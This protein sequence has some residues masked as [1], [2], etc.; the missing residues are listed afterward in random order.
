MGIPP[1]ALLL[2]RDGEAAQNLYSDVCRLSK[3]EEHE[4]Y[5]KV[6]DD[7]VWCWFQKRTGDVGYVRTDEICSCSVYLPVGGV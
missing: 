3:E 2:V 7:R 1:T 4:R 6:A 5:A